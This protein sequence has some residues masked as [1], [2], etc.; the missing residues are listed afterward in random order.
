MVGKPKAL[1]T[2]LLPKPRIEFLKKFPARDINLDDRTMSKQEII[3]EIRDQDG[4]ICLLN[5]YY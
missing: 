2:R 5:D 3:E 4:L 1:L